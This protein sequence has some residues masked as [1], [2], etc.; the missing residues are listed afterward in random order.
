MTADPMTVTPDVPTEQALK[1]MLAN[2]FRLLP[3]MEGGDVVG[4]V[5]I[6]DLAK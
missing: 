6:R 4:I 1:T 5:S 3:V 2:N